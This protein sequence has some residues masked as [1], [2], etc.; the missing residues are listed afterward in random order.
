MDRLK[1]SFAWF[2][3]NHFW[4][5]TGA[6][7]VVVFVG[8]YLSTSK[9]TTEYLDYKSKVDR[10]FQRVDAIFSDENLKNEKVTNAKQSELTKVADDVFAAWQYRYERQHNALNWPKG[11][12]PEFNKRLKAIDPTAEID[13]QLRNEYA[14]HI[15]R[16]EF[17]RIVGIAGARHFTEMKN[18]KGPPAIVTWAG[19]NQAEIDSSLT[20]RETISTSEMRNAQEDV[21]VYEALATIISK[22]N[23]GALGHFN[24]KVR[25]IA[26]I[27]VGGPAANDFMIGLEP[28]QVH[29]PQDAAP[30]EPRASLPDFPQAAEAVGAGPR[31]LPN[32]YVDHYGRPL[33][34]GA[35][36]E[37]EFRRLPLRVKLVVDQHH[38]S[39]LLAELAT[40]PL[41][42]EVKQ[43][44]LNAGSVERGETAAAAGGAVVAK[45]ARSAQTSEQA[46]TEADKGPYDMVVDILAFV[47]FYNRPDKSK[48][49]PAQPTET[50]G[51]D[52][53]TPVAAATPA[54]G[55][56]DKR[57][58]SA[59]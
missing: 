42:I 25:S 31:P 4:V 33:P 48:L 22:V 24:A 2:K 12:L 41:T 44:R 56:S 17:R 9:L 28:G 35:A 30:S 3:K 40:C 37:V 5:L 23:Q 32:R 18:A 58:A 7:V 55:E 6:G 59:L 38:I 8:W 26:E 50:V 49:L 57:L 27:H 46:E 53:A 39:N 20:W 15:N 51:N 45:T 21:W 19:P 11:L 52:A 13:E 34:T 16:H 54:V 47:Y 14:T 43:L 1:L 29:I 36:M 10:Q